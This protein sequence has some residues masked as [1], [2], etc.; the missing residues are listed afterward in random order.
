LRTNPT[1][2]ASHC[3][4]AAL[5]GMTVSR[6]PDLGCLTVPVRFVGDIAGMHLHRTRMTDGDVRTVDGLRATSAERAITDIGREHGA[7][8]ALISAD[9]ALHDGRVTR[10]SL[11]RQVQLCAGWPGV[12]A[13]RQ[14]VE[15]ADARSE[16]PLESMSRF[17]LEGLVPQPLLQASIRQGG[18]FLGRV[19][20]LW[21]DAGVVGEADGMTKY[22][23]EPDALRRE[24]LRQERLEK[25]GLIVVRLGR[26]DLDNPVALAA[27]LIN[28]FNR[29]NSVRREFARNWGWE[30]MP[31][32][33]L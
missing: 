18:V 28:A 11:R 23:G 6:L 12:R 31:P 30:P 24:K 17:K 22:D 21:P 15:F 16:S 8:A 9:A 33:S 13:A 20:F 1:A 26:N 3:S 19:D 25:L 32:F 4:A 2:V 10:T 7:L 14:A 29:G 5:H 27:R